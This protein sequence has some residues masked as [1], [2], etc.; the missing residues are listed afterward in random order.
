MTKSL[1]C[2]LMSVAMLSGA[3]SQ[4]SASDRLYMD[5]V[6]IEP[7]ETCQLALKMENSQ[8]MYGFQA[9]ITLPQGLNFD[10][11]ADGKADCQ[12]SDRANDSY[13]IVS[14][15]VNASMLRVGTFSLT[16]TPLTGSDGDLLYVSVTASE[17]FAG[18]MLTVS[19]IY[20][21]D[22]NDN[23]VIMPDFSVEIG[24]VH[25]DRLYL[26]DEKMDVNTSRQVS[27]ILDNETVF[28]AFQADIYT[29]P[30]I[31]IDDN[32]FA[33][34]SRVSDGHS[35]SYK[36]HNDEM[37]RI[38]VFSPANTPFEGQSGAVVTFDI[39][40][41]YS[42]TQTVTLRN[43][44]FSTPDAREYLLPETEA[45]ITVDAPLSVR[46]NMQDNPNVSIDGTTITV[47]G[48]QEHEVMNLYG[49]DGT[50]RYSAPCRGGIAT[51]TVAPHSMYILNGK[52]IYIP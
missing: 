9:D 42:G 24:T 26:S 51:V 10:T 21:S 47:R 25:D 6:N 31:I 13:T 22:A 20:A 36:R 49:A 35:I 11:T 41:I 27:L 40:A 43:I 39:N 29:S 45:T 46:D 19:N 23:D 1:K 38:A 37:V 48:L 12:L 18:G 30:G 28:T 33:L 7:G 8:P 32:S 3:W 2:L 50:I 17:D 34:A 4:A 14:N 5:A 16:H 15:L 52:K 44:R